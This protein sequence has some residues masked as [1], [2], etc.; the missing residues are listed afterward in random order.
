MKRKISTLALAA[1]TAVS[2]SSCGGSSS[3]PVTSMSPQDV[4]KKYS[5][6]IDGSVD[7]L[8]K[9]SN[10]KDF[11]GVEASL[12]AV[13]KVETYAS[14][15]VAATQKS[16]NTLTFKANLDA[17]VL[18]TKSADLGKVTDRSTYYTE[19]KQVV[20]NSADSTQ[21]V[22]AVMK[23]YYADGKQTI[24]NG[25][26]VKTSTAEEKLAATLAPVFQKLKGILNDTKTTAKE[27]L[28][29]IVASIMSMVQ[30]G[31][32]V[33]DETV[34]SSST[35]QEQITA[36]VS[37]L[38]AY[39][40]AETPSTE[41]ED[42]AVATVLEMVETFMK[43]D[44]G[45]L[46]ALK[47][48]SRTDILAV[49]KKAVAFLSSDLSKTI[50]LLAGSS[51][52]RDAIKVQLNTTKLTTAIG[53]L[54]KSCEDQLVNIIIE[55]EKILEP[56]AT[57]TK[58]SVKTFLTGVTTTVG[59]ALTNI[60]EVSASVFFNEKMISG[61]AVKMEITIPMGEGVKMVSSSEIN[62]D[63]KLSDSAVKVPTYSAK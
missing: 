58:D 53:T 32:T 55:A 10:A 12:K 40:T 24:V 8:A 22:N 50:D 14:D 52:K 41:V 35:M 51:G 21:N 49:V 23:M 18:N 15:K 17:I 19:V 4:E 11:I 45:T 61:F 60:G 36:W 20:T 63:F 33:A 2:L 1:L 7:H 48:N 56:N 27:K 28:E 31:E 16:E 46:D 13:S 38:M 62:G 37:T 57:V 9:V 26:D 29:T 44:T 25:T 6:R 34:S 39:A 3:V 30:G 47:K 59:Q 5:D 54:I 42:A 43:L